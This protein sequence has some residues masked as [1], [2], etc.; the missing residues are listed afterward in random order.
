MRIEQSCWLLFVCLLPLIYPGNGNLQGGSS[1]LYN[2][3]IILPYETK[4]HIE[5]ARVPSGMVLERS[6]D[7][8]VHFPGV[9]FAA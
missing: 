7:E 6:P 8:V 2:T 5:R 9:F 3:Y 4:K 1:T